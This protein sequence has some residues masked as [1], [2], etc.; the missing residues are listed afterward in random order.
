MCTVSY[1]KM[2]RD[3]MYNT[4]DEKYLSKVIIVKVNEFTFFACAQQEL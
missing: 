3:W 1:E 2:D 4:L